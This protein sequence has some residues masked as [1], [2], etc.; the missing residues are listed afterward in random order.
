MDEKTTSD[1]F[2]KQTARAY[3][4]SPDKVLDI[5]NKSESLNRDFYGM[6]ENYITERRNKV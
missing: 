3:D 6:L 2:I 5:Y 1:S 4:M